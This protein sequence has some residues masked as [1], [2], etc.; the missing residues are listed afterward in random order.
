MGKKRR[1][2]HPQWRCAGAKATEMW[3]SSGYQGVRMPSWTEGKSR[4]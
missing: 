1:R 3:D 2:K 4:R